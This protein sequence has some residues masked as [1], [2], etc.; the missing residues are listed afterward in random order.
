MTPL[1]IKRRLAIQLLHEA[2]VA[3]PDAIEGM[4]AAVDGEPSHF[5]HADHQLHAQGEACWALVYSHPL[6]A[7]VPTAQQLQ[8]DRLTL[9][10]SLNTKGVLELR[11]WVQQNG[12]PCE[13]AVS[14]CD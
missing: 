10:I 7:A 14:I 13:R 9:M 8:P 1:V 12:A 3:A 6:A 5:V 11:A 2:Q 4:V